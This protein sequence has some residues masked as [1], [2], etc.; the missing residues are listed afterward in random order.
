M[1]QDKVEQ[2]SLSAQCGRLLLFLLVVGS[3]V[4]AVNP[5]AEMVTVVHVIDG[6][7]VVLDDKRRVRLLSIN[8]PEVAHNNV[9]TQAGGLVAKKALQTMVLNKRVLLRKDIEVFDKYGRTLAFLMIP[10]GANINLELIRQGFVSVSLYPPNLLF[11]QQLLAAQQIAEKKALGLWGMP[12]YDTKQIQEI[13]KHEAKHWG[14]F[15]AEVRGIDKTSKGF[16]LQL[17]GDAYIWIS[18]KNSAYFADLDRY[19][20]KTIEIRGW[21]RKWGEHW[22]IQTR[23]PSQLIVKQ[24]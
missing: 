24:Q 4:F 14:R 22:S 1:R 11:S 2:D 15:I 7:T 23:H 21:P 12:T 10:E 8:A 18:S 3:S 5:E 19:L 17:K 13:D 6:D 9:L 16:K 20:F